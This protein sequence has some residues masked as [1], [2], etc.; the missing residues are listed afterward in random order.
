MDRRSEMTNRHLKTYPQTETRHMLFYDLGTTTC[1]GTT[2]IYRL[3]Y[4]QELI[5]LLP[6]FHIPE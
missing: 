3:Y 1:E 2:K 5:K 6:S 4:A